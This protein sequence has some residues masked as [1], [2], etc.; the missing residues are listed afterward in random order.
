MVVV[1]GVGAYDRHLETIVKERFR[2]YESS[3][4]FTYLTDLDMP[5]LLERLKHLP[6]DTIVYHTA[7]SAGWFGSALH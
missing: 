3:L 6:I 1:G 2:K 4:E 7:I 5:T